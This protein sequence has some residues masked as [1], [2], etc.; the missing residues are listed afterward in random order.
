MLNYNNTQFNTQVY[1]KHEHLF[2]MFVMGDFEVYPPEEAQEISQNGNDPYD[3]VILKANS[4][5]ECHR[6]DG[7]YDIPKEFKFFVLEE[8]Q[9]CNFQKD[10]ARPDF[11]YGLPGGYGFFYQHRDSFYADGIAHEIFQ[12]YKSESGSPQPNT[13]ILV[14]NCVT[15]EFRKPNWLEE[16][17]FERGKAKNAS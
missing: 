2:P 9:K 6:R 14:M 16:K 3:C 7:N 5:V 11:G 1:K 17:Y 4:P 15:K 13:I 10:R 12:I 8:T